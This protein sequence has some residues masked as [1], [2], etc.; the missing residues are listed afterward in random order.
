MAVSRSRYNQKK[1]RRSRKNGKF[2]RGYFKPL[3]EE[4]YK[5]PQ[6]TLMNSS[7]WP[8]YRSSWELAFMRYLDTSDTIKWWASEAFKVMYISPKDGQPHRYYPDF[9]FV[10]ETGE[11]HI[12]EIKPN[13]QKKDLVNLAK[14]EA[15]ERYSKQ[16]NATFSVITEIELKAWGLIK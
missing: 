15:A 13:K 16:I 2:Q 12:I 9:M 11:K 6:D 1:K 7:E 5:A 10:T 14:W 4:K 8:E 3:N